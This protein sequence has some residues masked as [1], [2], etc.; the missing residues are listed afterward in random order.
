MGLNLTPYDSDTQDFIGKTRTAWSPFG[1]Q[2]SEPSRWGH[3]Y[4]EGYEPPSDRATTAPDA[5]IPDTAL[6]GVES[7]QTIY[8]SAVRGGTISGV[9]PSE[10]LTVDD[11]VI[12]DGTVSIDVTSTEAGTVD[13]FLWNG[14]ERFT[15]VW[16][17]SCADDE[18]GFDACAATDGAAP[19][20]GEDLGGKLLGQ[21]SVPVPVGS[22]TVTVELTDEAFE[23]LAEDSALLMSF[24]EDAGSTQTSG[25]SA[26]AAG[27]AEGDG[28]N[29][30]Y[31]PIVEA[32]V[33]APSPSPGPSQPGDGG[34]A[35]PAPGDGGGTGSGDPDDG[36]AGNEDPLAIT[37]ADIAGFVVIGAILLAAGALA[38]L[39]SRRRRR[40]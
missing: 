36:A 25:V 6:R 30:W 4:L 13:A 34:G 2:Q 12:A 40:S 24:A 18:Y 23:R 20:W 10:A 5:I 37:G 14:D 15:P 31:F 28:V 17:S 27:T 22:S 8:Q 26:L 21:A 19:P 9:Q 35:S 7:P 39:V 33:V 11:V 32:E 3:A 1:S 29:A 16:T 38:F